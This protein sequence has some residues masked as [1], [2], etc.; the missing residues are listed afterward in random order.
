[1]EGS[2]LHKTGS[3]KDSPN[4]SKKETILGLREDLAIC[5]FL[6][7]V[8]LTCYW[9][10]SHHDFINYDDD[11]Y[12]TENHHVQNGLT[13]TNIAWALSAEVSGNWHPLTLLSHM[14]D[15]HWFGLNAGL[16]HLT[17]LFFHIANTLLLFFVLRGMTGA[18]W[19]SA[20]VAALFALHP[21]HI[22]SVAW[23]AE[24]K[25]VLSTFFFMLTLWCYSRYAERPGIIRYIPALLFFA[26]GL[27]AKPMLVTLPFLL[28]L[29]DYWPL[30][31]F[32][33]G[34]TS[35]DNWRLILEKTPFLALSAASCMITW[36]F[37]Q[38]AGAVAPFAVFPVTLRVANAL[39]SYVSY[40]GKM[41][42]P[43]DL[44]VLYPHPLSLPWWHGAGAFMLLV[45]ISFLVFRTAKE[46]PYF[47]VGWLWYIGT[48]VPVIGLVQVGGQAMADRYSY[49]PLI[50]LFIS[51]TWGS[52]DLFIP[53]RH[54]KFGVAFLAAMLLSILSAT[55][56]LQLRHWNNSI[57]LFERTLLVSS[58]NYVA[59]YNIG[60]ALEKEGRNAEA[61][62]H[63]YQ[64]LRIYPKLAEAHCC[65]GVLYS[66]QD[67]IS[68]AL[69]H[70]YAALHINPDYAEVHNELGLALTK[71][72]R[73]AE[74]LKHYSEAL[75]LLPEYAGAH[76]NMGMAM[77]SQGRVREAIR[78]LSKALRI[79]PENANAHYN[80]GIA[81]SEQ[82][83]I[84]EAIQYYSEA[85]RLNPGDAQAHNN[86]AINLSNQGLEDEAIIH[87][88]KALKIDPNDAIIHNNMGVLML[89]KGEIENAVS[90]FQEAIKIMPSLE[91]ARINL[92]RALISSGKQL[93]D[94]PLGAKE[95]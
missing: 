58:D 5:L 86:L 84:T 27:M 52:S 39:V 1:M 60:V 19:K 81:M 41:I 61:S 92:E 24:R 36:G 85:L 62:Q 88:S 75:R 12:V 59:H 37:Q 42:W 69:R 38:N 55:T 54:K 29:L 47:A 33:F 2:D 64:A 9:Q 73:I 44:A 87:Y 8:T 57:T 78:H 53:F 6:V 71:Q 79:N 3:I 83:R 49:I 16:H 66:K 89:R 91:S 28:L 32:Q 82:G 65:L 51:I 63:Y 46:R 43:F 68:L 94:E 25:D 4:N 20:F 26:L 45:L 80:M 93:T 17:S 40:I 7:I 70:L 30:K 74:A 50:G 21:L 76:T 14:L 10:I 90:H 18:L 23:V 31:R 11:V 35:S 77:I 15:C 72:G 13:L 22:E 34:L 56:F 67:N 95:E 48:L